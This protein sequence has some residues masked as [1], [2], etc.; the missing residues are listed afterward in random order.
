MKRSLAQ[1]VVTFVIVGLAAPAFAAEPT[2]SVDLGVGGFI[3][4]MPHCD[5]KVYILEYEHLVTPTV[6]LFGRG[7]EVVYRFDNGEYVE[8]GR[9]RGLEF[10]ARYYPGGDMRGFFVGASLGYWRTDWD[11]L[12]NKARVDQYTGAASSNSVRVNFDIGDR[13][14]IPGTKVSIMPQLDLGN[15][16]SS[17]SCAITQPASQVGTPCNQKSEVGMYYFLGLVVGIAF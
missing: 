13:I 5:A 7:S 3:R 11:F 10:G 6:A 4:T 16:F 8:T 1:C 2:D 12:H 15:F 9:P 17:T 14:L